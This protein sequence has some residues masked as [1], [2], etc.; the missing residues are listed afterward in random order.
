MELEYRD[1]K[2][3]RLHPTHARIYVPGEIQSLENSIK[4]AGQVK[5]PLDITPDGLILAGSRRNIAAINLGLPQVPVYVWN[6]SPDEQD[7]HILEDNLQ[8]VKQW[9][10]IANEIAEK[11]RLIGKKQGRRTDTTD[12]DKI[13]TLKEIA[14]EL[15]LKPHA[16]QVLEAIHSKP[17]H[18]ALLARDTTHNTIN[19]LETDLAKRLMAAGTVE[20]D[21]FPVVD[22][23][24]CPCPV[25]HGYP[26]RI[27][28]DYV[29]RLMNYVDE[30][31]LGI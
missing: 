24:P 18:H 27:I 4:K 15:G 11:R 14:T 30:K 25:C 20:D 17:E 19:K 1:P 7:E 29:H 31:D 13:N 6:L 21:E 8:R 5:R 3:L 2:E 22:L 16:V 26:R 12:E 28:T 9:I 10:E 23:E